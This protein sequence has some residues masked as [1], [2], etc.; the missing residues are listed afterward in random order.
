LFI[1]FFL[2]RIISFVS[3]S[4]EER[5]GGEE[6]GDDATTRINC[7]RGKVRVFLYLIRYCV[8]YVEKNSPF[9]FVLLS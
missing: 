6:G 5:G 2:I 9:L 3:S 8:I 7:N 4:I 1:L